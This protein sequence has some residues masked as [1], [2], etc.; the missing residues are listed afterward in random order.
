MQA[1]EL[2]Q[3]VVAPAKTD[4]DLEA[5]IAVRK[6]VNPRARPT[7]ANLRHAR[8]SSEA[9]LTF[10]VAWL[11]DEPVACGFVERSSAGYA[12]ADVTVVPTRRCCGI[13]SA[14]LAEASTRASHLGAESLQVEV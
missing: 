11:G 13:G 1:A 5:L 10:L 12:V 4:E 8:D 2:S 7:V 3:L 9:G 6:A 14:V